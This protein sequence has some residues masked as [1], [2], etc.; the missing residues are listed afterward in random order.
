MVISTS[1][2][3]VCVVSN[4]QIIITRRDI[5]LQADETKYWFSLFCFSFTYDNT[6]FTVMGKKINP[7]QPLIKNSYVTCYSDYICIH[8]YYFP[9]GN[10]KVKY[11]EIQLCE[12][13][14]VNDLGVFSSKH[15]GMSLTPVWYVYSTVNFSLNENVSRPFLIPMAGWSII[16]HLNCVKKIIFRRSIFHQRIMFFHNFS[17]ITGGTVIWIDWHGNIIFC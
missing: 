14:S 15:W 13:R 16:T 6:P 11:C 5:Q 8:W 7:D 10:K 3:I 9:F 2:K 1:Y 4:Q 12:L 17:F